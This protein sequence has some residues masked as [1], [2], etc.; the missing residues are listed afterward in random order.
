ML[1][2]SFKASPRVTPAVGP[3]HA[4]VGLGEGHHGADIARVAQ[5]AEAKK[6]AGKNAQFEENREAGEGQAS[7]CA[8]AVRHR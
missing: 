1:A 6:A 5:A 2:A 3:W 7:V 8:I 4:G